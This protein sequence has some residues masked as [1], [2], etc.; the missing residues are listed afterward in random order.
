MSEEFTEAVEVQEEFQYFKYRTMQEAPV[1]HQLIARYAAYG[2]LDVLAIS[3]LANARVEL[4]EQ[5]LKHPPVAAFV[6]AAGA[7]VVAERF[8][9]LEDINALRKD[10]LKRAKEMLA[11]KSTKPNI[12]LK[13]LEF[14]SNHH[15]DGM[16]S[17]QTKL[18]VSN[19]PPG[20]SQSPVRKQL[21]QK[22]AVAG[23]ASAQAAV[24]AEFTPVDQSMEQSNGE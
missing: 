1:N 16:L 23:I 24:E 6:E 10:A 3:E 15:P 2:R 13:I 11:D 9:V 12:I 4:V 19:L 20:L 7:G 22:A 17:K 5:V 14:A 18:N 8:E 21:M